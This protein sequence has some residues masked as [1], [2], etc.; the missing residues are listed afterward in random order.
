MLVPVCFYTLVIIGYFAQLS[1]NLRGKALT[2]EPKGGGACQTI[3][4]ETLEGD[5]PL[6]VAL[7]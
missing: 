7:K 1:P 2:S 6:V 4:L 3:M 5:F